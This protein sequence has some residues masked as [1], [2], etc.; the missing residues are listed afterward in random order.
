MHGRAE[1]AS[2]SG[3]EQRIGIGATDGGAG[4]V[5]AEAVPSGVLLRAPTANPCGDEERRLV[6]R[7]RAGDRE[8]FGELV[9]HHRAKALGWANS[10]ARDSAMA[11]DIVQDALIRAFLH[12]GTLMN[13]D[14]FVPWLQRI[15]RNQ[16]YMKM[17]R[18]GPYGKERP[19]SGF[20]RSGGAGD[21]SGDAWADA[22]EPDWTDIDRILVRLSRSS[23]EEARR[24]SDPAYAMMKADT[25]R[26][27]RD[28][29]H[30]L[31]K[32]ERA[33][34]EAHFFG[35]LSPAEIAALFGTTTANVYNALSRSRAKV[36]RERIRVYLHGYVQKR[37]SL[38][39]PKRVILASPPI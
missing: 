19:F 28:L 33:I 32:R 1:T 18:G 11:E 24:R 21:A 7:A 23:A 8:A 5:S 31:G 4:G 15:V 17:R 27:L 6:E 2:G 25:I 13:A 12:L 22:S 20:G 10:I 16:A 9:R 37:A 30:C 14:R 26:S 29:L 3:K 39:L 36:S 35:E 34:F 38:G